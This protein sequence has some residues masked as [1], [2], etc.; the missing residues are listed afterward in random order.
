M[1][2]GVFRVKR[3]GYWVL[4]KSA[5]G[6]GR[7]RRGQQAGDGGESL[8]QCMASPG[9]ASALKRALMQKQ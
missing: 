6:C 3:N 2:V 8:L 7:Q 9:A 1:V 5:D 4:C